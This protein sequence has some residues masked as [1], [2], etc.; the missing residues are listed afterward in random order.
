MQIGV[1]FYEVPTGRRDGRVS[2]ISFAANMPEVDDSI[3]LLKS[4]F[5]QKGLSHKD[6]VLLSSGIYIY[7]YNITFICQCFILKLCYIIYI[8]LYVGFVYCI[9]LE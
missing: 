8:M 4:K 3:Q 1:P 5:M 6:L 7:K 9:T 2:D